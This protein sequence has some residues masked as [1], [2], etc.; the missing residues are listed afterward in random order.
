MR[1]ADLRQVHELPA[2][3]PHPRL[4]HSLAG[5]WKRVEN[6]LARARGLH[7]PPSQPPQ[8]QEGD[9]ETAWSRACDGPR[10]RSS[11][12]RKQDRDT[13]TWRVTWEPL[14]PKTLGLRQPH[15]CTSCECS[16]AERPQFWL[17]LA[18]KNC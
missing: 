8:A 17:L 5:K 1:A 15:P 6:G 9:L 3:D 18:S 11:D 10:E 4:T 12:H 2:T 16:P 13:G 7:G 14:E